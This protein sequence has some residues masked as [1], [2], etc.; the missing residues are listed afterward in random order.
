M[1]AL[2]V[3]AG[4]AQ[5]AFFFVVNGRERRRQGAG[6]RYVRDSRFLIV[7]EHN[8]KV[9]FRNSNQHAPVVFTS[10]HREFKT[11]ATVRVQLFI[12]PVFDSI[13]T[14]AKRVCF[15]RSLTQAGA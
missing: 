11:T 10:V 4:C 7:V 13:Q 1:R 8:F 12:R 9:F 15:V 14:E 5:G 3:V 2:V 6:Y